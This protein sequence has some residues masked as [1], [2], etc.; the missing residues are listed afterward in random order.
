MARILLA[1]D[2]G[3]GE[4]HRRAVRTRGLKRWLTFQ[5]YTHSEPR[6]CALLIGDGTEAWNWAESGVRW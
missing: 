6:F 1:G 5:K 3:V 4:E 2:A